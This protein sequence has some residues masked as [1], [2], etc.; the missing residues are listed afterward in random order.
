MISKEQLIILLGLQG[1]EIESVE[2]SSN[3]V[4]IIR[5]RSAIDGCHCHRCGKPTGHYHGLGQEIKLRHLPV[6]GFKTYIVIKP[7]RYQC[8]ACDGKPTTTQKLDWYTPKSAFT[9]AYEQDVMLSLVNSTIQDVSIK[10]DIGHGAIEGI[11]DRHIQPSV[12]WDKIK[13]IEVVGVDEIA[14]KKGHRDFVVIVSA[15]V[16]GKLMVLSILPDRTKAT[17]KAFFLSIPKRLRRTVRAVCSDLYKGFISAAKEVFGK[18]V[19]VCAD[20]F[21]VAK[22]YREGLDSLRK[23]EMKRLKKELSEAEYKSLVK[24]LWL[25]RRPFDE[26]T[27]DE[28]HTLNRLFRY[29]PK[30]REAYELC[31]AL[32]SIYDTHLSKGLGKRKMK[33]WMRRV[34]NSGLTCFNRFLKTLE[35]NME[36]IT[37]YFIDRSSSGFVEGLNNKIKVLKRRCYGITNCERLFQRLCLDLQGY[38]M[39]L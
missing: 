35:T 29:S 17:V 22:L 38:A 3:N 20:R 33:G 11:L 27:S 4:L 31:D 10:H 25:V 6:F 21:H 30:I 37:N 7:K 39:F 34:A 1:I 32:T 28:Q 23:K 36:E 9:K 13:S 15:Y 2:L 18:R 14:L 26:L 19:A 8:Q 12:D 16:Q 5:V 24:V